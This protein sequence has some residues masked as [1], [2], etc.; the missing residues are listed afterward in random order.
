MTLIK[1]PICDTVKLSSVVYQHVPNAILE[2]SI[3]EEV[4][5]ILPK[6]TTSRYGP[7]RQHTPPQ[8]QQSSAFPH[9][10]TQ[11]TVSPVAES[12]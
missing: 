5:F 3:G 10:H 9:A 7:R 12:A 2:S 11:S 4:V 1:M 6:K 8:P